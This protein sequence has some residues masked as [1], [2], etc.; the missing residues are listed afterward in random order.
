MSVSLDE[1]K[2]AYRVAM[3]G[4]ESPEMMLACG[5]AVIRKAG[6]GVS[7][8]GHDDEGSLFELTDEQREEAIACLR[9]EFRIP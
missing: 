5:V 7:I 2:K 3:I 8:L 9:K 6:G 4:E 1:M